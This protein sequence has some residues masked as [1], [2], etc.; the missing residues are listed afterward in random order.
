MRG[1]TVSAATA[2]LK[3]D[4]FGVSATSVTTAATTAGNVISESPAEGTSQPAGATVTLTVARAPAEATVPPVKF[5]QASQ[6]VG[7]LQAA[8]FQVHQTY[9]T[10]THPGNVGVVVSQTPGGEAQ[11]VKG[12]TVTI[13]IGQAGAGSATG[14]STSASGSA[15]GSASSSSSASSTPTTAGVTTP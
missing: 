5:D 12:S 8:G 7:A 13:V 3:A 2:T 14:T 6:A 15:S 9:R 11:A 1:E 10:V 4:G